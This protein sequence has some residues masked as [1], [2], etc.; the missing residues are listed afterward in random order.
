MMVQYEIGVALH[1][2]ICI[3]VSMLRTRVALRFYHCSRPFRDIRVDGNQRVSFSA[4]TTETNSNLFLSIPSSVPP[5]YGEQEH[6]NRAASTNTI[7]SL[8]PGLDGGN[9]C[10]KFAIK[11]P[12]RFWCKIFADFYAIF[13]VVFQ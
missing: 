12:S 1:L 4:E 8:S 2:V 9:S 6:P 13:I 7:V 3:A 10:L 5:K 11:L